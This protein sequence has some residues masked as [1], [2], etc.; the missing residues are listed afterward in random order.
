MAKMA[1]KT[2]SSSLGTAHKAAT[3][4]HRAGVTNKTNMREFDELCRTPIQPDLAQ[5]KVFRRAK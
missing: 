1:S 5:R 3:R 4:L 2:E